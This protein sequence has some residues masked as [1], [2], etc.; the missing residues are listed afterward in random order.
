MA[1]LV[2]GRVSEGSDFYTLDIIFFFYYFTLFE[3]TTCV[4]KAHFVCLVACFLL[5]FKKAV[6]EKTGNLVIHTVIHIRQLSFLTHL[7]QFLPNF[8]F[9]V[10]PSLQVEKLKH[11]P[12]PLI[13]D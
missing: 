10:L 7:Q 2:G 8:F 3:S 12:M 9:V 5:H 11:C 13:L 1:H 6:F 4:S